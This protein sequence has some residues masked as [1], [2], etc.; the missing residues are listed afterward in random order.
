MEYTTLAKKLINLVHLT[1]LLLHRFLCLDLLHLVQ[2]RSTRFLHQT[3]N[4]HGLHVQYLRYVTL[5]IDSQQ[6]QY[7]HNQEVGIVHVQLHTVK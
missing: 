6:K 5:I 3:Q 7:L 1:L 4:L 2:P